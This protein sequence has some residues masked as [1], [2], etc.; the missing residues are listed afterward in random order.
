LHHWEEFLVLPSSLQKSF[1]QSKQYIDKTCPI[2]CG[3]LDEIIRERNKKTNR[4]K[5]EILPCLKKDDSPHPGALLF[6]FLVVVEKRMVWSS[7]LFYLA[8]APS[9]AEVGEVSDKDASE[10]H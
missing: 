6:I 1:K 7:K 9:W 8:T 2:F 4:R 10:N 3:A 5:D